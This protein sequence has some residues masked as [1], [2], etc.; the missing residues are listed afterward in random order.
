MLRRANLAA[1][2]LLA[3]GLGPANAGSRS[4]ADLQLLAQVLAA[5]ATVSYSGVVE[6][7]RKEGRAAVASV[8]RIEH[9]APDLTRRTYS[10]PPRFFG[11]SEIVK[12]NLEFSIDAKSRRIIATQSDPALTSGSALPDREALIRANYRAAWRGNGTFGGRPT[13]DALLINKHTNRPTMFVRVDRET[14]IVLDKQEFAPGGVM[15]SE[16]RLD[17]V[18]YGPVSLSAFALPKGYAVVQ[19]QRVKGSSND[20]DRVVGDAGFAARK[21]VMPDGFAPLDGDLVELRGIRT[22][23][24]LYSDGIRSVSLFE[25][26]T[27]V[28]PNMA[29]LHPD[30]LRVG[31]RPAEYAADGTVALLTWNDGTL[32]YTLV[33]ELGKAELQH[34]ATAITP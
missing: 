12:G 31:G 1:L 25:T 15:I 28:T 33:G 16:T 4:D 34:L 11:D 13:I 17:Q 5:P 22:V 32:Y 10:A 26:A 19:S 24:L 2:A 18:R 6:I 20:P 21:P 27:A 3:C 7:V 9:R 29:P 23:Q 30:T 14:K 8:Y